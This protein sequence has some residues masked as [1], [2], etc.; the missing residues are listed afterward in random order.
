MISRTPHVDR[1]RLEIIAI[2]MIDHALAILNEAGFD[3]NAMAFSAGLPEEILINKRPVTDP[4]ILKVRHK[5]EGCIEPVQFTSGKPRSR[6][7]Q[8]NVMMTIFR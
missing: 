3:Q 2:V 4:E 7:I 5:T 1:E 8:P 6:Y